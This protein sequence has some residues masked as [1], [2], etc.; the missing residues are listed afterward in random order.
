MKAYRLVTLLG[1]VLIAA[2]C[3][4]A[5]GHEHVGTQENRATIEASAP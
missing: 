5:L 4:W 1:A 3:T 2:L